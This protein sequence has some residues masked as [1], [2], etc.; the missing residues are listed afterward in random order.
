MM[1]LDKIVKGIFLDDCYIW[2]DFF[3]NN[4][5]FNVLF[6]M[7]LYFSTNSKIFIFLLSPLIIYW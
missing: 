4:C 5:S 2:G 6:A 3:F 1:K 7:L